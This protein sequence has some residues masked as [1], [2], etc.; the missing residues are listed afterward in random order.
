MEVDSTG[1]SEVK[2]SLTLSGR[3]L[4]PPWDAAF[5]DVTVKATCSQAGPLESTAGCADIQ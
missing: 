1:A 4:E 5:P 2:F 3:Q